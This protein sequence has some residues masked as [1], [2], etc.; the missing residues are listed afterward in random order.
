MSKA[1]QIIL[2]IVWSL[3]LIVFSAAE[4][5][6]AGYTKGLHDGEAIWRSSR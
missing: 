4:G 2:F 6:M 3:I 1:D 5:H